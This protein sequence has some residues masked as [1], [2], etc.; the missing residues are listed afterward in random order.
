MKRVLIIALVALA[1]A[2]LAV[3]TYLQKRESARGENEEKAI[4]APSSVSRNDAGEPVVKLDRETQERIGLRIETAAAAGPNEIAAYGRLQEDPSRVFV[5]RA[6]LP[7]S[8]RGAP[9]P[10]IG[11]TILDGASI[12]FIEPR[13]APIDRI[14]FTER[15]SAARAESNSAEAA[16]RAARAAFDRARLLNAD[17]KNVSDRAVQ[18]ADA[19]VRAEDARA[20]AARESVQLMEAALKGS[21][22]VPLAATYGGEV[23]EVTARPGEYVDAGQPVLKLARFDTLIARVDLPPGAGVPADTTTARI[24]ALGHESHPMAGRRAGLGASLDSATQAQPLLFRVSSSHPSLRPGLSI[25]AYFAVPRAAGATVAP[26]AAVVRSEG[27]AWVYV[28]TAPG[29]FTRREVAAVRLGD[30]VVTVGAAALLSEESKAQIRVG[31]EGT[32]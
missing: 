32:G 1:A 5:V 3:W 20:T 11:Q 25:T 30:R 28:E 27:K 19:K 4:S 7:G 15:L 2:S 12:G 21:A 31:E 22:G 16:A 10:S 6:P 13:L 14:G 23:V 24:I 26:P 9:W 18:E 17:N 29:E 8:V